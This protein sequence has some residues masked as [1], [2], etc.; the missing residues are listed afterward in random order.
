MRQTR[1][2]ALHDLEREVGVLM[3]RVKRL[4]AERAAE[5]HPD[6]QPT[7]YLMLSW[8][9]DQ[10]P[11]RASALVCEFHVDKGAVSRTVQ[12]LEDLGLL[13]R[14]PDPA[15]GRATLVSASAEARRRLDGVEERRREWFKER[16]KG[17]TVAELGELT[18]SLSRYNDTLG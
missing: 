1:P 9:A 5:V 6:L 13:D 7:S 3:R 8:V 4:I 17:W 14:E 18:G 15:D 11:V 2:A 12:H 16:L 10:G